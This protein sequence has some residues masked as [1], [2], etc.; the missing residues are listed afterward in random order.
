M[1]DATEFDWLLSA[2]A[3]LPGVRIEHREAWDC[4]I[5]WVADRW[6]AMVIPDRRGEVLVNLKGDPDLNAALVGEHD[7]II[8][9]YHMNKRHWIS[10]RLSHPGAVRG[11][12]LDLLESSWEVTVAGLPRR[13]AR[14]LLMLRESWPPGGG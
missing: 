6:F 13:V 11:L 3:E 14:P 9:A 12:A 1:P 10:L 2:A 8:P 4:L 7:W 5:L